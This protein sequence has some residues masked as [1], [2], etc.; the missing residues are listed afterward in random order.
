M[1]DSIRYNLVT[2]F[3]CAKCGNKLALSYERPKRR[4]DY[5]PEKDDGIT[6]A[7]KVEQAIAVHPCKRCYAAATEPIEALRRAL[8]L[9][10][11]SE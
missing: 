2:S 3:V 1:S 7:M 10:E 11:A 8:K 9:P 6:G 5:E 4:A